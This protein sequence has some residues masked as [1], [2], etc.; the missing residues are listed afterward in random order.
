M[1]ESDV[2]RDAAIQRFE[3]TFELGWKSMMLWLRAQGIDVR[4]PKDTLQEAFR[5]GLIE[6]GAKWSDLQGFRNLTSHT[7]NRDLARKVYGHIQERAV[8][9]FRNALANMRERNA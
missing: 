9:L 6:D 5:Q 4:N 7:Y 3:F 1:S 8:P 2:V